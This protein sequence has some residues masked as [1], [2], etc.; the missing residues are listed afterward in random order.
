MVQHLNEFAAGQK[1]D[2][3]FRS[4]GCNDVQEILNTGWAD[5]ML[6]TPQAKSFEQEL[7]AIADQKGIPTWLLSATDVGVT[8]VP[9]VYE[10]IQ[11]RAMQKRAQTSH[12]WWIS[13]VMVPVLLL[14][15]VIYLTGELCRW[16]YQQWNI[17]LLN[18][19]YLCTGGIMCLY[20]G[21]YEGYL[22]AKERQWPKSICTMLSLMGMLLFTP[23]HSEIVPYPIEVPF[24]SAASNVLICLQGLGLSGLPFYLLCV[25][26]TLF[27]INKV[28][29]IQ[30]GGQDKIYSINSF[31]HFGGACFVGILCLM[32]VI[33]IKPLTKICM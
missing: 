12:F 27:V 23:V 19:I 20:V 6:L 30:R 18:D 10:A 4:A 33:P 26:G 32:A 13:K 15:A 8:N 5:V 3:F 21:I 29:A 22:L 7:R 24:P 1:S 28:L 2:F 31:S 16:G 14:A 9:F 17:D 11:R 25:L